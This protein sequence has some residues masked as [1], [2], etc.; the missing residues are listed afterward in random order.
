MK[1]VVTGSRGWHSP[2]PVRAAL[3]EC[4]A[5][6]A[7]RGEELIVVHGDAAKGAD[8]LADRE[9][10]DLG[11]RVIAEPAEWGRFGR[12]AGPLR[13]GRML[14]EHEVDLV[15]A[16]RARGKST[17]TDDMI[18]QA[19]RARVPVR[20]LDADGVWHHYE[21]GSRHTAP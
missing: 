13:N 16:F 14:A 6:A 8:R 15:L 2:A 4:R 20:K 21:I 11:L 3:I 17:G 12:G 9:A 7:E 1:V 10:R 5:M 19:V 18:A